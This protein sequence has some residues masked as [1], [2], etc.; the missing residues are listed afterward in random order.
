MTLKRRTTTSEQI[1]AMQHLGQAAAAWLAGVSPR[2]LRDSACPRNADGTYD[3]H[4]VAEWSRNESSDADPMLAGGDSPNLE[5]YRAA[6]AALAEMDEAERRG[7]L[8]DVDAFAEWFALQVAAPTRRAI[9]LL[10]LRF[11]AEA[12]KI[13]ADA[14][15]EAE[16]A[17][18]VRGDST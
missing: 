18:D 15:R 9:E 10:Q 7:K 13:V 16:E 11:G 5:R 4:A 3:G 6:R 14:L 2:S 17:V 8:V 1:E 12:A